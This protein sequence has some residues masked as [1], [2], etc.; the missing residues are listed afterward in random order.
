MLTVT[1][2]CSW[3]VAT[4]YLFWVNQ[5]CHWYPLLF[6]VFWGKRD[7]INGRSLEKPFQAAVVMGKIEL[8]PDFSRGITEQC[9]HC[10]ILPPKAKSGAE[11]TSCY[12]LITCALSSLCD[13]S[14][15]NNNCNS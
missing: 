9:Y 6:P 15:N 1:G 14:N 5:W 3:V 10:G 11:I 4:C 12:R 8:T 2:L 13:S 7:N